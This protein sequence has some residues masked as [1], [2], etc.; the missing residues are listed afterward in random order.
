MCNT[1]AFLPPSAL[2]AGIGYLNLIAVAAV[3]VHFARRGKTRLDNVRTAEVGTS[4]QSNHGVTGHAG[5][6]FPRLLGR[7]PP[8]N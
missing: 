6:L 4:D 3:P 7:V 8:M 5:G 1:A 2:A